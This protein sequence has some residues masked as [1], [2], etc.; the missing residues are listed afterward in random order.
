MLS[1]TMMRYLSGDKVYRGGSN[2]SH[3]GVKNKDG[4]RQRD[5]RNKRKKAMQKAIQ[6]RLANR[7]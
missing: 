4:F 1:G 5:L 2:A 6:R 3:I 7:G